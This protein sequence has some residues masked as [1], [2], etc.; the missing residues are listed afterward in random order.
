[1]KLSKFQ[2]PLLAFIIATGASTSFVSSASAFAKHEH[3][4]HWTRFNTT[5]DRANMLCRQILTIRLS[6]PPYGT[7]ALNRLFW[8]NKPWHV[9][10]HL[11]RGACVANQ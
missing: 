4:F 8:I 10:A 5:Q 11:S 6:N 9:W 2:A 1:M 3:V 7:R